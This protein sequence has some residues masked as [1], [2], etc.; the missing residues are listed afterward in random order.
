MTTGPP[1]ANEPRIEADPDVSHKSQLL[2]RQ[3]KLT[4][5]V[6]SLK[7]ARTLLLVMMCEFAHILEAVESLGN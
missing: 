1:Q 5:I 4:R 6:P 7:M 2:Q 3:M